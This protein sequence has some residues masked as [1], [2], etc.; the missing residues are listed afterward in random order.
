L[1][2]LPAAPRTVGHRLVVELCLRRSIHEVKKKR[3][4]RLLTAGS[5]GLALRQNPLLQ[6][7][8]E[9]V[10]PPRLGHGAHLGAPPALALHVTRGRALKGSQG[11]LSCE[12]DSLIVPQ[13]CSHILLPVHAP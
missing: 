9:I 2:A 8:E 10:P 4:L 11:A 13:E 5:R 6:I 7:N 1:I 3:H 12:R